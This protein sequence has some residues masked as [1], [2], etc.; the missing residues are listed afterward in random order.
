MKETVEDAGFEVFI[1]SDG[2][3]ALGPYS[4]PIRT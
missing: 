2:K 1:A 3:E 4:R